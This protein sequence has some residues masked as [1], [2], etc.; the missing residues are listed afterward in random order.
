MHAFVHVEGG[1]VALAQLQCAQATTSRT[2]GGPRRA[3]RRGVR[4]ARG[5]A[6]HRG[7]RRAAGGRRRRPHGL[8]RAADRRRTGRSSLLAFD[9][10]DGRTRARVDA[11]L[12]DDHAGASLVGALEQLW[13]RSRRRD[14]RA[15]R[16][17]RAR[18]GSR[19]RACCAPSAAR[20]TIRCAG[21]LTTG[22]RRC[23]TSG[24]PSRTRPPRA[25]RSSAS[26]RS[27]SRPR[28]ARRS[29][30][31]L[32]AAAVR[33]LERAVDDAPAHVEL[34]RGARGA[35]A[36]HRPAARG[37]A[38]NER[39]GLDRAEARRP[40]ALLSQALR[41]QGKLDGALAVVD[42]GLA[43]CGN[44]GRPSHRARRH[45]RRTRRL[46]R[47][48]RRRGERRSR[49]TPVHPPR[50]GSWRRSRCASTTRARRRRSSTPRSRRPR[51][52]VDVLRRA[53]QLALVDRG[54]GARPRSA[55][56]AALRAPPRAGRRTTRRRS[57]GAGPGAG[58][59]GRP[60]RARAPAWRQV[61][62]VAPESA[63]GA[64]AQITRLALDDPGAER[65][66][67]SVLRAAHD[68]AGRRD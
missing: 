46:R 62:R 29:I 49:G 18:S 47:R 68:G 33:A 63:S 67:Q 1:G 3:P 5:V 9:S 38:P 14:R 53:V 59:A 4:A 6:R 2:A 8:V 34:G 45:P 65:E 64:E 50:S 25:T 41:A 12:D 43:E 32:A 19:S 11:P 40:Y 36:P 13:S 26:R 28:R 37:R 16:T 24:A 57:L 39:R 30:R 60:P 56:R 54:R 58:R 51:A 7:A 23:C 42:A 35:A 22:S 66:L 10:R 21:A 61:D 20:C 17:S 48:A 31:K 55:G 52:H 27:R 15:A 44:D